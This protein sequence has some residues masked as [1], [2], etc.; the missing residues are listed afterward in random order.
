MLIITFTTFQA[1]CDENMVF[2][3]IVAV[4]PNCCHQ[5]PW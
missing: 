5:V 1:V 4:I 2:L 3:D